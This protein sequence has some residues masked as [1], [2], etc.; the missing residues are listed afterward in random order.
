MNA[1]PL[2]KRILR[3]LR[4]ID[5]SLREQ[6]KI[7]RRFFVG[8]TTPPNKMI[9]IELSRLLVTLNNS[10]TYLPK[11]VKYASG[12]LLFYFSLY[13]LFRSPTLLTLL[14][15]FTPVRKNT[16][17]ALVRDK[18]RQIKN[19][20]EKDKLYAKRYFHLIKLLFPVVS[21]QVVTIARTFNLGNICFRNKD[22]T[23]NKEAYA[24]L[25]SHFIHDT[26]NSGLGIIT[27]FKYRP[28][29]VAFGESAEKLIAKLSK[30]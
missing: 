12:L 6:E 1:D 21:K 29:S 16:K 25:F 13:K 7:R 3:V 28:A 10:L 19:L 9:D 20:V 17:G 26:V 30:S 2:R 5:E 27:G 24:K 4:L 15:K 18:F 8:N 14:H 22:R 23:L 11:T